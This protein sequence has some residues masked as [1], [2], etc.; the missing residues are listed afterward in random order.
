M[1]VG[2]EGGPRNFPQ[3]FYCS[4]VVIMGSIV[5]AFI[6]GNMAAL[7]QQSNK[8]DN[9][10]SDQLELVQ[11]TMK[12]IK[13][14]EEMQ[15]DCLAYLQYINETPDVFLDLNKFFKLLSP[16]LQSQILFKLHSKVIKNVD[17][18]QGC[19][20]IEITFIVKN[21]TTFLFLPSE[22]IIRFGEESLG[23]YFINKG[24]VDVDINKYTLDQEYLDERTIRSK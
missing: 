2:N 4:L 13:I 17:I 19:S 8:K 6:F 16:C 24:Y 5:T 9:T 7:L 15:D 1:I 3:T 20:E 12:A 22:M 10:L 23:M 21:L 14:P 18:F 11:Q